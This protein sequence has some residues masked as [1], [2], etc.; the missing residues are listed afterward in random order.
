[1]E[2][3]PSSLILPTTLKNQNNTS[4]PSIFGFGNK[5]LRFLVKSYN[6]TFGRPPKIAEKAVKVLSF[7]EMIEDFFR[8]NFSAALATSIAI[9][10]VLVMI[11]C[12]IIFLVWRSKRSSKKSENRKSESRFSHDLLQE[13]YEMES[14]QAEKVRPSAPP[15]EKSTYLLNLNE[16]DRIVSYFTPDF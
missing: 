3:V 10:T 6:S 1:M 2:R 7:L 16:F 12:S 4:S 8:T 9:G 13:F 15:R 14:G 11:V 5:F